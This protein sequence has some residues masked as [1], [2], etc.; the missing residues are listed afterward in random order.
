MLWIAFV[1][2]LIWTLDDFIKLFWLKQDA[3]GRIVDFLF[4][5]LG[6]MAT[7]AVWQAI[8]P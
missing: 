3:P 2:C 6:L 1:I 7:T 8:Y 4:G 5:C